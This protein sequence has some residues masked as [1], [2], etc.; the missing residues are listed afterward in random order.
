MCDEATPGMGGTLQSRPQGVD[1]VNVYFQSP[2]P[3]RL[4]AVPQTHH[5]SSLLLEELK[6][7]SGS[8][9]QD[10]REDRQTH[11]LSEPWDVLKQG[12][13]TRRPHLSPHCRLGQ[14]LAAL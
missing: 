1:E 2:F 10:P 5:T 13:Q 8:W 7:L 3:H 4:R 6:P 14:G 12:I 11:L 9:N